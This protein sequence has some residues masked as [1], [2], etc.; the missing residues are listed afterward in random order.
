MTW[1]W[2]LLSVYLMPFLFLCGFPMLRLIRTK[3]DQHVLGRLFLRVSPAI[4]I[5]TAYGTLLI[6]GIRQ[7]AF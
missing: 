3:Q 2:V 7:G 5:W 4:L 1:A 6:W